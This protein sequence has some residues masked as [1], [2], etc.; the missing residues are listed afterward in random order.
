MTIKVDSSAAIANAD[1]LFICASFFGYAS[2]IKCHMEKRGRLVVWFDDRPSAASFSKATIRV[3]PWL[4]RKRA[5]RYFDD[6][7]SRCRKLPIRDIFV[8]KGE[9]L[10]PAAVKRM[11]AAFPHARFTL[12]FWDNFR[13]MP[14]DSPAKAALFDRVLT[15]DPQD[16]AANPSMVY[17][18]LFFGD[19]FSHAKESAQDIDV[20]F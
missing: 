4:M 20:L 11:R 13:N 8:I 16:A 5:E 14:A 19:N 2:E 9:T 7:I 17:R 1:T 3:A 6:I 15:F 10:S 18:P 12:Y